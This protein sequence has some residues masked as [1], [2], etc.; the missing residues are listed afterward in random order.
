MKIAQMAYLPA[1]FIKTRIFGRKSPLQ[2]VIF[3]TDYCNLRCKH[4]TQAGHA[5]NIMKT[6][7]QI[8]EELTYSYKKGARFVDFEG[9]E[10]TLWRDSGYTLNDLILL[11][12]AIG[13]YSATVTT[14]A[15][16]PFSDCLADSIWVSL[17][18]Y[19]EYH[20]KVRGEGA[21]EKLEKNIEECGHQSLSVNMAINRINKDSVRDTIQFAAD[22]HAIRLISLNF[23][24]PYPGTEDLALPW[25]ER[26]GIIDGIISLKRQGYPIMNSISGL[27]IMKK[28]D[29][30]KDCWVTNFITTEG[31]RLEECPG[32]RLN[33]CSDCGFCMAGEMYSVLRLKPDTILAGMKLRL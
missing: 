17:D 7:Q 12:K 14:N 32:S 28:R 30:K 31:E 9:G 10:P 4:C 25:E 22:H 3:I 11:S 20:D 24:T 16:Q 8:Q 2:T 29:F 21:F 15:Q 33:V 5:G 23:H 19:Q 13:F 1:W 18:G 6:Y 27:K 26:C